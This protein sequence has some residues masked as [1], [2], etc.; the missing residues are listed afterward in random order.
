MKTLLREK[1]RGDSMLEAS[2]LEINRGVGLYSRGS[3]D[4]CFS[5]RFKKVGDLKRLGITYW[6]QR[7]YNSSIM[8]K[9]YHT[10]YNSQMKSYEEG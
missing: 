4:R 9:S 1:R 5:G 6:I 10:L 7:V 8:T 3:R 2:R